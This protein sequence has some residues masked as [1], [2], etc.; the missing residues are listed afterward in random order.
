MVEQASNPSEGSKPAQKPIAEKKGKIILTVGKRK[1]AIARAKFEPGKGIVKV[2]KTPLD[3]INNEITRMKIMEPLIIAGNGW[4]KFNIHLN[5]RGGGIMGQ[6]DAARQAIA[7]GLAQ[8]M[9][10]E[11]RKKFIEYDKYMIVADS[12]RT[13][14][15]KP[16]RSS[17]G[18]R[19][20]K[21]RSKR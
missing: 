14:P 13:E 7:K 8:L 19:R 2:N 20:Y 10:S 5:I 6:A 15:H 16:P 12:R 4:K 3:L 9:G 21:Q 17:Q 18:P 1:K 11:T